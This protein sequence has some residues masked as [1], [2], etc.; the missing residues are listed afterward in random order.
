MVKVVKVPPPTPTE[1]TAARQAV[2]DGTLNA[3]SNFEIAKAM[4]EWRGAGWHESEVYY[5][6]LIGMEIERE[7]DPQERGSDNELH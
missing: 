6:I 5:G 4:S 3:M 1:I 2:G 7:P